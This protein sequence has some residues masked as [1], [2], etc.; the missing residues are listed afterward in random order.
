MDKT[1]K[2]I[3]AAIALGLWANAGVSML[4]PAI[5]QTLDQRIMQ[6]YVEK[7]EKNLYSIA[8]GIHIIARGDCPNKKLC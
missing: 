8:E 6:N 4:R 5:A 7:I 1:T 3:L 2:I